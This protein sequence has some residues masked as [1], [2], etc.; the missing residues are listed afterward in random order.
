MS[1]VSEINKIKW[2]KNYIL[3]SQTASNFVIQEIDGEE[4][5]IMDFRNVLEYEVGLACKTW[6]NGRYL[7]VKFENV[8]VRNG[9]NY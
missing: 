1:F 8:E 9:Y 2:T 3:G 7:Q 4:Y 6:G 5:L